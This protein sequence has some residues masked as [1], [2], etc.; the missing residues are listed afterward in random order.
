M[1]GLL[2]PDVPMRGK[3]YYLS[4]HTSSA[5]RYV[6][7]IGGEMYLGILSLEEGEYR[8]VKSRLATSLHDIQPIEECNGDRV[9]SEKSVLYLHSLCK[10]TEKEYTKRVLKDFATENGLENSQHVAKQFFIKFLSS[11]AIGV[12]SNLLGGGLAYL[13]S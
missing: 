2:L 13:G 10:A 5:K 6:V 1:P 3:I 7:N 8:V 11:Y 4:D 9:L 12:L